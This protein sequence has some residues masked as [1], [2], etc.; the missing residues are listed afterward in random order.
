M[1]SCRRQ[2]ASLSSWPLLWG[3]RDQSE[4]L[5]GSCQSVDELLRLGPMFPT[6]RRR[7]KVVAPPRFDVA[8][9]TGGVSPQGVGLEGSMDL[10]FVDHRALLD[11][12][13][14]LQEQCA[15]E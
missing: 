11:S 9:V 8:D 4:S 5:D 6:G 7:C 12:G 15:P 2:R 10:V 3:T 14:I 13:A 1:S